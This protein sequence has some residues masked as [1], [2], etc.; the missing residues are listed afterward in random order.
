V[1][2][3]DVELEAELERQLVLPLLDEAARRDDQAA[4]DVAA[5]HQLLDQEAGHDRLART[6]VVGEQEAQRLARQHLAVDGADLVRQRLQVR[7]VNREVGVEQVR[8]PDAQSLRGETEELGVRV[9]A[10]GAARLLDLEP[11]LVRA[12]EELVIDAALVVAVGERQRLRAVPLLGDDGDRA[13]R[14]DTAHA[15]TGRQVFEACADGV[16]HP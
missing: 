11:R 7:R 4:P 10:P 3:D 12:V 1:T 13:V 15:G 6:G 16:G 8:E 5:D 14:E 9:E 2:R